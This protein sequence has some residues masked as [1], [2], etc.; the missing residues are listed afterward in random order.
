MK[1]KS[2]IKP[3]FLA[4]PLLIVSLASGLLLVS[5]ARAEERISVKGIGSF[6]GDAKGGEKFTQIAI[7]PGIRIAVDNEKIDVKKEMRDE[8][9]EYR[10]RLQELTE[11]TD[12]HWQMYQWCKQNSLTAF[13]YQHAWRVIEIDPNHA[14]ARAALDFVLD[15]KEWVTREELMLKRGRVRDGTEWRLPE[16]IER[17]KLKKDRDEAVTKWSRNIK[18]WKNDIFSNGPRASKSLVKFEGIQ[19]PLAIEPLVEQLRDINNQV[20]FRLKIISILDRFDAPLAKQAIIDAGVK[21]PSP[22]V[23][24]AALDIVCEKSPKEAARQY[25]KLLRSENNKEVEMAGNAMTALKD[26]AYTWQLIEAVVT[27]HKRVIKGSPNQNFGTD[28]TGSFGV[29]NSVKDQ[30]RVES[31]NNT[32]VLGALTELFPDTNFRFE[33]NR[34]KAWYL[35]NN[36]PEG[37]DLRRDP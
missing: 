27:E 4:T 36:F 8:E 1:H 6:L 35:D 3:T 18:A 19:D 15:G 24:E 21:D 20:D 37:E 28:S 13:A 34:W 14:A 26:P 5:H 29:G 12:S 31:I 22:K 9:I 16:E 17:L 32:S 30:V 25:A 33:E 11:T 23:R 7:G 2:T 10:K